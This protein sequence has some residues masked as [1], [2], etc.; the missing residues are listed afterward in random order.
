MR[1]QESIMRKLFCIVLLIYTLQSQA[2]NI[3]QKTF[4]KEGLSTIN[5][6]G[7]SIFKITVEAKP[8]HEITVHSRVEGENNENIVL[9]T[10]IKN[11]KLYI[12]AKQQPVFKDANDKLSAHKV[13]SIE[14]NLIIPENLNILVNSFNSDFIVKGRFDNVVVNSETGNCIFKAFQGKARIYTREGNVAIQTNHANIIASSKKGFIKKERI[15][16]GSN[17]ILIKTINGNVTLTRSQ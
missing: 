15:D 3:T 13:I 2:Q 1:I 9:V 10:E 6:N 17:E 16:S 11:N 4:Y 14:I 7:E 12:A 8:V 5:I